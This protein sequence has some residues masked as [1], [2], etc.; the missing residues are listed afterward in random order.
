MGTA[1]TAAVSYSIVRPARGYTSA[2]PRATRQNF[3][4]DPAGTWPVT[5]NPPSSAPSAAR[6]PCERVTAAK[7]ASA[8]S[9]STSQNVPAGAW[10]P[11]FAAGSSDTIGIGGVNSRSARHQRVGGFVVRGDRRCVRVQAQV[12]AAPGE[13]HDRLARPARHG[14]GVVK[15]AWVG[16]FERHE[17]A[18][19]GHLVRWGVTIP[20]FSPGR[21]AS[22]MACH[23]LHR[24]AEP[25][26]GAAL[27]PPPGA[28][29]QQRQP[30]ETAAAA[31]A[32]MSG[33]RLPSCGQAW[34]EASPR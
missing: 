12:G 21:R 29:L 13:G 18:S 26:P 22:S 27:S 11:N 28:R 1:C 33:G 30:A 31:T 25:G 8:S 19:G 10:P 23:R 20:R 16:R 15:Q 4:A 9:G 3:S 5:L 2:A 24:A 7:G 6:S 17:G 32:A 14:H 34:Q